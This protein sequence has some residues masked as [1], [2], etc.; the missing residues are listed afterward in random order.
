MGVFLMRE[1]VKEGILVTPMGGEIEINFDCNRYHVDPE[2]V[3]KHSVASVLAG[4][5]IGYEL[6]FLDFGQVKCHYNAA[7][8]G[9]AKPM[10]S[11]ERLIGYIV[12][13][14]VAGS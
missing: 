1:S 8:M 6:D 12:S 2:V 9:P 5:A 7:V 10:K 4:E 14:G 13:C 11:V 3:E